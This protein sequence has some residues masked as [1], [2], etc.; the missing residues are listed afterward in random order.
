MSADQIEFSSVSGAFT[1]AFVG[2]VVV[3]DVRGGQNGFSALVYQCKMNVDW[4]GSPWAYAKNNPRD[5]GP[6]SRL[7]WDS[8]TQSYKSKVLRED[9]F[10]RHLT[11]IESGKGWGDLRNA[12]SNLNK[13]PLKTN[14]LNFDHN[15]IWV[16]VAHTT[17]GDAAAKNLWIDD[18]DFLRDKNNKFPVIQQEGPSKG[19]Y[20]STSGTPAI[21]GA[22]E[23]LQSTHWNASEIP[24]CVWPSALGHGVNKG[25]FG[26]AI[27][28]DTGRCEGFFFADT[29]ST[30]KLGECSGYLATQVLRTPQNN[31]LMV[32]F[33]VFPRSGP[34]MATPGQ[35]TRVK[36]AVKA[37][38]QKL[39][40]VSNAEELAIFLSLGVDSVTFNK[41]G[42]QSSAANS[43][44]Y[45]NILNALKENG[46]RSTRTP[47]RI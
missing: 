28:N 35:Q 10:Q 21:S 43:T 19:Y 15:F 6:A 40:G 13:P 42:Y 47:V 11:P 34:G 24:Y 27:A 44:T 31:N 16:G 33:L 12:T 38:V 18:R 46:F 9:H 5:A 29:G 8:A 36:E 4:D 14:G 23:F 3:T 39:S 45:S 26:L 25:D 17:P 1:N 32:T 37:Q 30:T 20:V 41:K 7:V 2:N 22:S